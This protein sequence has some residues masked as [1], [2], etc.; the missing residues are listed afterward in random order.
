MQVCTVEELAMQHY[1]AP[2]QGGWRGVHC[3]GSLWTTLFGLLFWDILFMDVADAFQTAFQ[4]GPLD[5]GSF[6]FYN[7]R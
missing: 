3:E 1:A 6:D 2:E 5:Y 7:A 4:T